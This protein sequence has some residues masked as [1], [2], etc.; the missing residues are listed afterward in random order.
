MITYAIIPARGGS[1]GVP[2][3]NIRAL[4]GHPLIAYSI[5][6]AKQAKNISRIIVSTDSQEI[7]DAARSY[8]AET[9]FLRPAEL[10]LDSSTDYEALSHA[11]TWLVSSGACRTLSPTSDRLRLCGTPRS[12]T[13]PSP[14][15]KRPTATSL[16]SAHEAPNLRSSGSGIPRRAGSFRLWRGILPMR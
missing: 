16:R 8:G 12:W 1:K 9:P 13:K 11:I 14:P 6:A 7:A 5:A 15:C 4:G 10:A 2:G 3:K